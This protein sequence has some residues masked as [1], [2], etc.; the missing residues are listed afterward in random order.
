MKPRIQTRII[1]VTIHSTIMTPSII[2][3][4]DKLSSHTQGKKTTTLETKLGD[5]IKSNN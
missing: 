2:A 3:D 4:K 5:R 1:S